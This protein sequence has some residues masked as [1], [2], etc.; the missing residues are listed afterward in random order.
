M[1]WFLIALIGPIL[2][3]ITNHLDKYII[4]KYF[5]G[6]G[7][8]FLIIF[9]SVFSILLLPLIWIFIH[10]NIW[11][12]SC[13]QAIVLIL[14]GMLASMALKLAFKALGKDEA[15]FVLPLYQMIPVFTFILAYI[16]LGEKVGAEQIIGSAIIILGAT[17]LSLDIPAGEKMRFKKEVVILMLG[18][19]ILYSIEP[20][21][22]KYIA[23]ETSFW[24]SIFWTVIGQAVFGA[25]LFLFTK[26]NRD[27]FLSA[28]KENG[29]RV[30][31][32]NSAVEIIFMAAEIVTQFAT[33]LAPVALVL[34]VGSF[35]PFFIFIFGILI[36]IFFPKLGKESLEKRQVMQK[37]FGIGL[38]IAGTFF[39]G[40]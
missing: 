27:E 4:E 26:K 1:N 14:N 23:L 28:I 10:P 6:G 22:F 33:M 31:G 7:S 21:V 40:I 25:S 35:Q 9:S 32:I 18:S 38:I 24:I 29:A 5:K 20:V 16:F 37:V 34:T 15:S 8:G 19:S 17:V 36:T 30:L 11:G 13:P 2:Y 39:I 12:V 3:A